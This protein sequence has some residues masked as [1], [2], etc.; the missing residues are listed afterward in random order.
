MKKKNNKKGF[1]L[2]EA[3]I[4]VL[5]LLMVSAT[6][7]AGVPAAKR[8]YEKVTVSANAQVL[9]STAASALRDEL[10]A[11]SDVKQSESGVTFYSAK[12]GSNARIYTDDAGVV[13]LENYIGYDEG[14]PES[15]ARVLVNEQT[16]TSDLYVTY[17][18]I[19]VGTAAAVVKNL[20]VMRKSTGERMIFLEEYVI[21]FMAGA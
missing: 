17:D 14:A 4:A 9:I 16:S 5:I 3:L 20:R 10:G 15:T 21:H 12:T 1:T 18:S 7:A 13:M 8:A 6:V 11:A 2:A 19:E